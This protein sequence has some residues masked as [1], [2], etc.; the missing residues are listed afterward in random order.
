MIFF[1]CLARNNNENKRW[2]FRLKSSGLAEEEDSDKTSS[3]S[4]L[5]DYFNSNLAKYKIFYY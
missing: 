3:N 4:N 5:K 2:I 1:H